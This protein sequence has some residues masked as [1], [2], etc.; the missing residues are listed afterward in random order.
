M[1]PQINLLDDKIMTEDSGIY[2][3]GGAYS[4]LNLVLY[5]IEKVHS[6]FLKDRK[7]IM[8]MQ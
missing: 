2:T 6:L 5:L 1:F 7:P 8:M 3:S 4:Y